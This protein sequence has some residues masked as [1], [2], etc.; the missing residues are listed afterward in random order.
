VTFLVPIF[1]IGFL[2]FFAAFVVMFFLPALGLFGIFKAHK[3]LA[4]RKPSTQFLS[5]RLADIGDPFPD[6]DTF[7]RDYTR[8]L[9]DS[10]SKT[11]RKD[12]FRI[13]V[14]TAGTL[15]AT[16]N[17][18]PLR[19]EDPRINDAI[20]QGRYRDQLMR[21]IETAL[22]AP[23][24]IDAIR[25]TFTDAFTEL[26]RKTHSSAFVED[27]TKDEPAPMFTVPLY[28]MIRNPGQTVADIIKPFQSP[29][30]Q[31]RRLFTALREQLNRNLYE[32]SGVDAPAPERRLVHPWQY[33]GTPCEIVKA[34]LGYTPLQYI[35]DQQVPFPVT[36]ERRFE[37]WHLIGGTGWGKSQTLQHIIMHDLMRPDPPGL[38]VIDSQGD[39]LWK[40]QNLKIFADNPDRLIIIDPQYAPALNIFDMTTDRLQGY[41]P[42]IRETLEAGIVE[43]YHYIFGAIASEMTS[44]QGTAFVFVVRLMLAIEGAT[45]HTLL[46]LMEDQS[47]TFR[48]SPFFA[49]TSKLDD[50][51]RTFFE[52]QFFNKQAFGQTKQQLARRLYAILSVP[53]FSRSFAASKN[54]LDM[55]SAL[56]SGKVVLVNTAKHLLKSDASALFGRYM[57]AQVMAAAFERAAHTERH[58][59][60]L[61]IDEA[62]DVFDEN[63]DSLLVQARKYRL[64]VLFAH[65]HL[66][67]L[68]PALRSSVASNTTIKFAGGVSDQ[69]ARAL[70]ADM[71]TTAQFITSMRKHAKS[72]EFAAYIRNETP[73]ALR[74]EVPFGTME[75]AP[76][77]TTEEHA[78]LIRRNTERY[79]SRE[80]PKPPKPPPPPIE[81][82]E[83]RP[84]TDY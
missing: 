54:K 23:R 50:T 46:E 45:L 51:A 72:T 60:F 29:E 20:L 61:I 7:V 10:W 47:K 69:D 82:E 55:F 8:F 40:I 42:L 4:N 43:L 80:Q 57:I 3:K 13:L 1:A 75:A 22:D 14:R 76:R 36:D 30:I 59:A 66:Q 17:F 67:Q 16:H 37:H 35:F 41:T 32:A 38:V 64:G 2:L 15:Y 79:S 28:D 84:S 71:R 65:Q 48:D 24:I 11:P 25:Q 12:L 9:L 56:Q 81:D 34:Y 68:T 70:D 6:T 53:A 52:N 27:I 5:N 33:E 26:L 63:I 78:E 21:G 44:K 73:A 39:M 62:G 58:P 83:I 18:V 19:P 49:Y 74:L 31:Q 77:M